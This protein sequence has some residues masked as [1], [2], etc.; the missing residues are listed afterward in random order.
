MPAATAVLR[1]AGHAGAAAA[2]N[3]PPRSL[4]LAPPC[5]SRLAECRTAMR[6]PHCSVRAK[7]LPGCR[8]SGSASGRPASMAGHVGDGCQQHSFASLMGPLLEKIALHLCFT[9]RCAP[10]GFCQS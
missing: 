9:E 10:K 1:P 5:V 4:P 2:H 8:A 6:R 7:V 3:R